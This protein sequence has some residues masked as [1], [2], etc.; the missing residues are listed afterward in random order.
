M[1]TTDQI[2]ELELLLK[3]KKNKHQSIRIA[4]VTKVIY[5][6]DIKTYEN[7]PESNKK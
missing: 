6:V 5:P 2:N 3:E 4:D 7:N 1:L